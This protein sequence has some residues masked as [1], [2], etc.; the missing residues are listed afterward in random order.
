M[1]MFNKEFI[2]K[3]FFW[4]IIIPGYFFILFATIGVFYITDYIGFTKEN[5]IDEQS[6]KSVINIA[7]LTATCAMATPTFI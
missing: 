5:F 2:W 1:T 3:Y 4:L 7:F 6:L